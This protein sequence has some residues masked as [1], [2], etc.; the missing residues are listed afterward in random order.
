MNESNKP[1]NIANVMNASL[2]KV[3]RLIK[4]KMKITAT[5]LASAILLSGCGEAKKADSSEKTDALYQVNLLQ[6]LTEGDYEGYIKVS[7]L[8]E[9]GDTGIGTFEGV[10][11]EMIVIDG[12]VYQALYDGTV[13]VADNEETVPFAN[14]TYLDADITRDNLKFDSIN[15]L[16][17]VLT[18]LVKANGVNEF[19]MIRID[20]TFDNVYVRSELKQEEPYKPLDEALATDQREF[21]YDN[22]TGTI[23]GLYCPSYMS[24]LNATGWHLHFISDDHTKGGH[25]LGVDGAS[26]SLTM[27]KISEFTMNCSDSSTFN[28]YDLSA[29]QGDR[30]RQVEQGD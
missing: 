28:A 11:G 5:V 17:D 29:D 21:S 18:E 14:I 13:V 9:H 6:S 3:Q 4:G 10:N 19:Y 12:T 24:G 2:K 7:Q 1:T 23:V 30:I 25:V 15:E 27:D 22:I 16:K 20:G 8:K 26:S